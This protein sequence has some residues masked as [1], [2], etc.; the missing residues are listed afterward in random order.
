MFKKGYM[1]ELQTPRVKDVYKKVLPETFIFCMPFFWNVRNDYWILT[2]KE[3]FLLELVTAIFA[4]CFNECL[5]IG[6]CSDYQKQDASN[7]NKLT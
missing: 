2:S 6:V 7:I 1:N 3:T 4:K 5:D